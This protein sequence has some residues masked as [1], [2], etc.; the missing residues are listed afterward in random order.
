MPVSA[1]S[2][3]QIGQQLPTLDASVTPLVSFCRS[4]CVV[5]LLII[6]THTS[7]SLIVSRI[8][9]RNDALR[10]QAQCMIN[11][12]VKQALSVTLTIL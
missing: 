4:D 7:V 2:G 10:V 12:N 6:P 3:D 8:E 1:D 5:M 11:L 9:I